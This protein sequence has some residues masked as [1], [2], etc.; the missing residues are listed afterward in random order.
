[1]DDSV[2]DSNTNAAT[3]P[4]PPLAKKKKRYWA[5]SDKID[6]CKQAENLPDEQS[7]RSFCRERKVQPS[8][9]RRWKK[10]LATI[11][12]T[13]ES[14]TNKKKMVCTTGRKNTNSHSCREADKDTHG[15]H[16]KSKKKKS[17]RKSKQKKISKLIKKLELKL[18]Q[19][20]TD[21]KFVEFMQKENKRSQPRANTCK[22]WHF[23]IGATVIP[24]SKEYTITVEV[25]GKTLHG[26][27]K[28][29]MQGNKNKWMK[30]AYEISMDL[31][32][33]LD[34][35]WVGKNRRIAIQVNVLQKGHEVHI[36]RDEGDL[37]PQYGLVLGDF[38]GGDFV[39]INPDKKEGY[40]F[41]NASGLL[42]QM[43]G[44]CP[45]KVEPVKDGTRFSVY[46]FKSFDEDW[47]TSEPI[48]W[49][50]KV[51]HSQSQDHYE[52]IVFPV[53]EQAQKMNKKRK[54]QEQAPKASKKSKLS[55]E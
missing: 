43:D 6:M 28:D 33:K 45:H 42:F 16:S 11:K 37:S 21:P 15:C 55:S 32:T 30:R 34:P 22:C 12:K 48:M 20:M 46:F 50:P 31:M 52:P 41:S 40:R 19:M 9:L 7:F 44:R 5:L 49:P 54:Q 25:D 1:M 51:V 2:D 39:T 35:D 3:T 23:I 4:P 27:A 18:Y 13:L 47:K 53:K 29:P 8:Q 36:H 10:N 17:K 38:A 14:T 26:Y 24:Y